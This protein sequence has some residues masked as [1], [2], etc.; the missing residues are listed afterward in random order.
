MRQRVIHTLFRVALLLP[1]G[2]IL[3][4]AL[5]V[6]LA[7]LLSV[8]EFGV[9]GFV[10][11]LIVVLSMLATLG[12]SQSIVRFTAAYAKNRQLDLFAGV[13]RASFR[14]VLASALVIAIL[15]AVATTVL[16]T[17]T[18]GLFWSAALLVPVVIS[19]W[20][21]SAMRGLHLT[22]EAIV[23][24]QILLPLVTLVAVLALQIHDVSMVLGI[25]LATIVIVETVGLFRLKLLATSVHGSVVPRYNRLEWMKISIPMALTSL[26]VQGMMRWDLI[27][28]SFYL[29]MEAAGL[30]MAASRVALLPSLF[31]RVI[32]VVLSPLFSETYHSQN[33]SGFRKLFIISSIGSFAIAL[34]L[35]FVVIYF[36]NEILEIFGPEYNLQVIFLSFSLLVSLSTLLVALPV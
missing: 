7:R 9:F 2:L 29:G 25:Y 30:Y 34:P 31:D 17:H 1:L 27:V 18:V 21:E 22:A 28:V 32:G 13:L 3:N 14:I 36:P 11:S 10:Q 16:D 19:V 6:V 35:F 12:F 23:P 4:F 5:N 20:R 26:A 8:E 15:L 33:W 24:R